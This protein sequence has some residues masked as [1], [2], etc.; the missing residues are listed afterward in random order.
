MILVKPIVLASTD[1]ISANIPALDYAA[2]SGTTTYAIGDKVTYL[3]NN[4]EALI[5]S[6]VGITPGTD[7]TKWLDLGA[8]NRWAM[9]DSKVGTQSEYL[10]DISFS[11]TPNGIVSTLAL[12]NVEANSI[13]VTMTDP[14]DGIVYQHTESMLDSGVIDWYGYFFE[15]Y[16]LKDSMVLIDL[17]AYAGVTIDVSILSEATAKCGIAILGHQKKLGT[18]RYG[19]STGITDYSRKQ[20]DEFGV[21]SVIQRSYSNKASVSIEVGTNK[22]A[23]V[24]NLLASMR[25]VPAL[26]I[27]GKDLPNSYVYGFY[28]DFSIVIANQIYSDCNL[29]LEGLI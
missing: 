8:T 1:L 14:V 13:T 26:Y 6:L 20:V 21:A 27:G 29:E 2:Y 11:V 23:W 18:S 10:N 9:F 12:L 3:N 28:K 16:Y 4:Y 19:L 7:V 22:T 25:A 15:D 17:P 24:Q 5:S